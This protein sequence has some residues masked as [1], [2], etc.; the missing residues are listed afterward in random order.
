MKY[1]EIK[2]K[3]LQDLSVS[4]KEEQKKIFALRVKQKTMQ[5]QNTSEIKT[6]RKNVAKIK[7]AIN[8]KRE[9]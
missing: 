2:D 7:T 1:T 3:S 5:L 8:A 9:N 6:I 4:L